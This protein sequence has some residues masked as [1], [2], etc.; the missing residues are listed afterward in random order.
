MRRI[1]FALAI[2]SAALA[3]CATKADRA[4]EPAVA[5]RPAPDYLTAPQGCAVVIGGSV[6]AGFADRK[7]AELWHE[8]NRGI[9][10]SL[11]DQL[12]A[13]RYKVV[14]L[15]I[16]VDA[17]EGD[18]E[19]S[20]IDAMVLHRCN[21]VLQL[22]H[23]V[24]ED[25]KGRFF[26]FEV[27]LFRMAPKLRPPGASG[28]SVV[29]VGEYKRQYRFVRSLERLLEFRMDEFADKLYADLKSTESLQAL[30]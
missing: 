26:Q 10:D 20:M 11:Y 22:S 2:V 12:S 18:V 24:D 15:T 21:R 3:G 25:A 30:R 9:A 14:K 19:R 1:G 17:A 5:A 28:T 6:G 23:T 16:P 7:V 27:A 8:I 13:A 29:T 4:A